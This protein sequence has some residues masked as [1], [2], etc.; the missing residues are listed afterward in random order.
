MAR[1]KLKYFPRFDFMY[2]P[3]ME[4]GAGILDL[5]DQLDNENGKS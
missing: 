2:D 4:R 5:L 3:S 1:V